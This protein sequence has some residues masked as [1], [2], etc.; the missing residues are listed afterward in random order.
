M[1]ILGGAGISRGNMNFIG[2]M[3]MAL[4]VAITVEG[5]NIMTRSFQIIGQGLTRCHPHMLPLISSLQSE[6][7]DAPAKFRT[8]L[9]NMVGHV[10]SNFGLSITRGIGASLATAVRPTNAYQ[11]PAKLIAYH[12]A[13]LLRLSANFAYVSDLALLLGGRLKFEELMMGRMADAMGAIFLGYSTLHH[14]SRNHASVSGLAAV[15]ES[16]MLHLE[17]E[18]QTA[19]REI[20][21]NFPKPIYAPFLAGPFGW[22]AAAGIAPLGE[23]TRP[24][25]PPNDDLVKE[26]ARLLT[27][28]SAVNAMF[29]QH[30][31]LGEN[32]RMAELLNALPVAVEADA[33]ASALR[34]EN[35]APSAQE[36]QLLEKAAAMREALVEVDVHDGLG[37]ET[38]A[39]GHV[40]PA[41]SSTERRLAGIAADFGQ[42]QSAAAG[43][44]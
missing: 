20:S 14:F 32:T 39:E 3:W 16:T 29:S 35:R 44:A 37:I 17:V 8:Q 11:D 34:K 31:Y 18:A 38:Y 26:V 36:A 6:E 7:K 15:A 13:Q 22:L 2:N 25:R 40:R 21:R 12:E 24:Y 5:A 1:D 9:F 43:A 33:I 27:T 23:F 28:P 30:L 42:A 41:L 4:P 10:L 19:L